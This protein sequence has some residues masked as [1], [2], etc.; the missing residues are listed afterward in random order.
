MEQEVTLE[1]VLEAHN[2]RRAWK[3]VKANAGAAGVDGRDIEHTGKF[4][5][6]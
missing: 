3:A 5:T 4:Q 6:E 1:S 2:M